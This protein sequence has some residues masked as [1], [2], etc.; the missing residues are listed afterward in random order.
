MRWFNLFLFLV[1]TTAVA[2][3]P[4][5]SP[6]AQADTGLGS[7]LSLCKQVRCHFENGELEDAFSIAMKME[8]MECQEPGDA[9]ALAGMLAANARIDEALSTLN[10][11]QVPQ[12]LEDKYNREYQRIIELSDLNRSDNGIVMR[13]MITLNTAGNELG[14]FYYRDTLFKLIDTPFETSYFPRVKNVNNKFHFETAGMEET[15]FGESLF[16]Y[17]NYEE[18]GA[19]VVYKD[20]LIYMT[21]LPHAAFSNGKNASFYEVIC[22]NIAKKKEE[23]R[24]ALSAKGSSVMHPTVHDSVIVVSSN[25]PGGFGG[26]DLY[27]VAITKDGFGDFKNLG[28]TINSAA[29]EVFPSYFNDTLYFATDRTDRGYGG[30]DIYKVDLFTGALVNLGTPINSAY[31]D[32]GLLAISD[33]KTYMVSNRSGSAGGDDIYQLTWAKPTMFF[34]EL[35]GRIATDDKDL[36]G[37]KIQLTSEDGTLV[38]TT[39]L[40]EDGFFAF[41]HVKGLESYE[42][43][44]VDGNLSQGSK[45][46]LFGDEGDVIKEVEVSEEGSFKFQLL[47]PE[48]YFIQRKMV[49]DESVLTIDILGMVASETPQEEGFK[50][51]LEDSDG[52]LI[53]VTTTDAQG[54]F[55]FKSVKPDAQYVITTK[56]KDPG[57]VIHILDDEGKTIAS[58]APSDGK[59]FAYVRLT[60]ASKVI[61]LTNEAEKKVKVAQNE[62]F[63][64]PILYFGLNDSELTPESTNSL[65]RLSLIMDLNPNISLELSGHTDSRGAASYNLKLSQDRIN[66]VIKYLV[67]EGTAPKRITGKGYGETMLL[68][69]CDDKIDCTEEEHAKNRRTEIRISERTAP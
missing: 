28:A 34:K 8:T 5:A 36:T 13:N 61:T 30:L 16:H 17:E 58:I 63:N 62:L 24:Y 18:L 64:I 21:A 51:Y 66:A 42:I 12:D 19:G 48:D 2:A 1:Y 49:V 47:T 53:G 45:L 7:P 40:D 67:S 26:M 50:I 65:W 33:H 59:E 68:N 23:R 10:K 3:Q 9:L 69:K 43:E 57:A 32:F 60:D 22:I 39:S 35:T 27:E 55:T 52:E 6:C 25:M 44:I 41:P 4:K 20:S 29:N 56:V 54:N 37:V 14:A 15:F 46:S 38:L 11:M 31:D